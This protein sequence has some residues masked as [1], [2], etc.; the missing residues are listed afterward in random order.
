MDQRKY[1][2][3]LL[4]YDNINNAA[5]EETTKPLLHFHL[6]RWKDK[7]HYILV[8]LLPKTLA[9][10]SSPNPRR[11]PIWD[12]IRISRSSFSSMRLL[13]GGRLSVHAFLEVM[14]NLKV[15]VLIFQVG[16]GFFVA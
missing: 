3:R 4:I 8:S 1:N 15:L 7:L 2:R 12:T 11:P 9:R 10:M 13:H 5:E 6:Y 14:T 16:H